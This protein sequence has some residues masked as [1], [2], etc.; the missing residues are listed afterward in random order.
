VSA[1]PAVPAPDDRLSGYLDGELASTERA[2][3]ERLVAE[4][5]VWRAELDEVQFARNR[6]RGLP[7]REAPPG[8]FER[9]LA[10]GLPGPARSVSPVATRWRRLTAAAVAAAAVVAVLAVPERDD[11]AGGGPTATEAGRRE[12]RTVTGAVADP[13]RPRDGAGADDSSHGDGLVERIAES[14]TDAFRW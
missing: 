1:P 2:A 3:V 6:L 7:P 11:P 4:S 5:G 10:D 12:V 13:D 9:L 8:F 14:F